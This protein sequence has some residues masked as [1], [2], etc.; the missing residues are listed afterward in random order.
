MK[1][2]TRDTENLQSTLT[3]TSIVLRCTIFCNNFWSEKFL[4]ILKIL[5]GQKSKIKLIYFKLTQ[6]RNTTEYIT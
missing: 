5:T 2:Q 6:K 4:N 3:I 1:K